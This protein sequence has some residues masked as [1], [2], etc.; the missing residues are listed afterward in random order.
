MAK[1]LALISFWVVISG[2]TAQSECNYMNSSGMAEVR[3]NIELVDQDH[4]PVS[5]ALIKFVNTGEANADNVMV[6]RVSKNG[7]AILLV[8]L[9]TWSQILVEIDDRVSTE[10]PECASEHGF[11]PDPKIFLRI[12][13]S[14][15]EPINVSMIN[16]NI[17]S[18][19]AERET[20]QV[21]LP[22]FLLKQ[23]GK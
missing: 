16:L 11:F 13:K 18:K 4:S 12:E 9:P 7:K 21:D 15:Y 17:Q 23:R 22:I 14:G 19:F 2:A 8:N 5:G 10:I 20:L 3:F 1:F 6:E